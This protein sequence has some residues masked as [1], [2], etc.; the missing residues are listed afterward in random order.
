[1]NYPQTP[2]SGR[3][4]ASRSKRT[5]LLYDKL[6]QYNDEL[7]EFK[8][9]AEILLLIANGVKPFRAED[10][11]KIDID[12]MVRAATA[13]APYYHPKLSQT[14][15][16]IDESEEL[17]LEEKQA[18]LAELLKNPLVQQMMVSENE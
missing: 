18:K 3:P 12:L 11:D 15:V 5:N 1:M 6:N 13:A 4:K 10:N 9:P 7:G 14:E 2:Q 8:S 17:S 16:T